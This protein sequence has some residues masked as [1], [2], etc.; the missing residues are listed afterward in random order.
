MRIAAGIEYDGSGF[1]GWQLQAGART[2]QAAVEQA[3]A[4]VADQPVRAITAGRTDAGV[5]AA[6][7]VVHF[8]TNAH[9][10]D[11]SWTR[12]ATS[13]LPEDVACLWTRVVDAD[14]HARFSATERRYRYVILNRSIRPTFLARR[15]AWERRPLDVQRMQLAAD[16]LLGEHD[17][18]AFRAVGCQAKSPVRELR[19]LDVFRRAGFICI[20]AHANAFLQHMV[21]N[22]AGVLL[23]IGAGERAPEWAGEVLATRDRTRGGVTAPPEGLYLTGIIYPAKYELPSYPEPHLFW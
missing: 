15:V 14:F 16:L 22:L 2:V 4:T 9:R 17:F 21:R 23:S 5:H 19:R 10:S 7:Q 18:S 1:S 11:Y 8:D 6:C 20:D 12:G 3:F 13:N